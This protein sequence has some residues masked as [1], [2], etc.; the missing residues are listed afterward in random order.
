MHE[1]W[2]Q[3]YIMA[4]YRDLGFSQL[5]GPFSQ[6]VDFKGIYKGNR[7]KVEAEWQYAN[8][9]FHKHPPEWADMLIVATLQPPPD[10]R[11][12]K[13]PSQIINIDLQ[14]VV[15]WAQPRADEKE[16]EEFKLYP[17]RRLSRNLLDLYVYYLKQHYRVADL[18]FIGFH[19]ALAQNKAQKPAGFQFGANGLELAFEGT[20]E[21]KFAWDYW[22]NIAHVIA[23]KFKLKPA[24]HHSTWINLLG[25]KLLTGKEINPLELND[26]R[27]V[28][29]S[30]SGLLTE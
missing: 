11:L 26:F 15:E 23:E 7:V 20:A 24:M 4:H 22:L 8:Y 27:P 3:Q 1:R 30:I 13:L 6:G 21:D 18:S 5:K 14:K 19:L 29:T 12:D 25:H 10:K 2:L 9:F 28:F 17:W 16:R